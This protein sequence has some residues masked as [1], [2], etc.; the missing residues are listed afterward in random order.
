MRMKASKSCA[1]NG[2][3]AYGAAKE[4]PKCENQC[5]EEWYCQYEP[6]ELWIW[7]Q[8]MFWKRHKR[9]DIIN[10]GHLVYTC[11]KCGAEYLTDTADGDLQKWVDDLKRT[12]G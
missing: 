11:R 3:D 6:V 7:P 2:I 8:W 9:V 5:S 1:K 12:E 10:P 4:C